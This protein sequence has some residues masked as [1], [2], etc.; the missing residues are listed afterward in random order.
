MTRGA[1]LAGALLVATL[2]ILLPWRAVA[3]DIASRVGMF[4]LAE[5]TIRDPRFRGGVVLL[6]QDDQEGSAGLVINRISRLPLSA[7]L[8]EASSLAGH[9]VMLSY[10]G[11]VEPQSLLALV[12]INGPSPEPADEVLAGLYITGIAVLEDWADAPTP[13]PEFR[14]FTGYAG[15]APG[16]LEVEL[17][18]KDWRIVAGDI[19]AVFDSDQETQWQKL[20]GS[21]GSEVK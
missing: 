16:Q 21:T 12:R 13:F 7:V 2:S 11:P 15:W 10:G 9:G 20:Q 14:A 1:T 4:L 18:R 3:A 6:V 8:P 19:Q 5:E 17:A